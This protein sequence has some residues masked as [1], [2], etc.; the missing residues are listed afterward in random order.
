MEHGTRIAQMPA[1]ADAATVY[2]EARYN[3]PGPERPGK[4]RFCELIVTS[5][6]VFEVPGPAAMH[7]PQPGSMNSAPTSSKSCM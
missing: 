1:T 5:S 3:C 7:A 4:L 2:G 6:F